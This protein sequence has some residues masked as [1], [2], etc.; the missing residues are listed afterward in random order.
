LAQYVCDVRFL[1]ADLNVLLQVVPVEASEEAL[2]WG[3]IQ[4]KTNRRLWFGNLMLQSA[5][6]PH[7]AWLQVD[8][9][10][11]G[12]M[13]PT[14][15]PS[16]R[17]GGEYKVAGQQRVVLALNGEGLLHQREERNVTSGVGYVEK[18]LDYEV[19]LDEVLKI[20]VE[21]GNADPPPNR[22]PRDRDDRFG[23]GSGGRVRV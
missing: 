2:L 23:R 18:P 1:K 20:L 19:V 6:P 16:D 3:Y 12:I 17:V 21:D 4:L 9:K 7:G 10:V 8:M 5:P 15:R 22:S 13:K 11:S 14:F